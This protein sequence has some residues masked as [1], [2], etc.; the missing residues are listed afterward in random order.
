MHNA[1]VIPTVCLPCDTTLAAILHDL[2]LFA[3]NDT[4]AFT[5]WLTDDK[6]IEAPDVRKIL[7]EIHG[8][9]HL[10]GLQLVTMKSN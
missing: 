6:G 7:A 5:K 1:E 10:V 2:V 8:I 9:L 4:E 3:Q